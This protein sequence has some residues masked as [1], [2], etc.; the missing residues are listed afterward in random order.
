MAGPS[1]SRIPQPSTEL[2]KLNLVGYTT[3]MVQATL[4]SAGTVSRTTAIKSRPQLQHATPESNMLSRPRDEI[5]CP[6]YCTDDEIRH[7]IIRSLNPN[8]DRAHAVL[9]NEDPAKV[10]IVLYKPPFGTAGEPLN[11]RYPIEVH[12]ERESSIRVSEFSKISCP[13]SGL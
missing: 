11:L 2:K 10:C 3:K 6:N 5:F 13:F 12:W 1:L 8:L 7:E 9:G 4:A